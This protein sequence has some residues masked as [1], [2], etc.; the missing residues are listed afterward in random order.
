MIGMSYWGIAAAAILLAAIIVRISYDLVQH[1]EI[2]W[3]RYTQMFGTHGIN[4]GDLVRL[5]LFAL[6]LVQIAGIDILPIP[7]TPE[8]DLI[9]RTIGIGCAMIA[10]IFLTWPRIMRARTWGGGTVRPEDIEG[11]E[12]V[13][14][15]AYRYT[16]HPFYFGCLL[17]FTGVELALASYLAMIMPI[18]CYAGLNKIARLE[19]EHLADVY[20]EEYEKYVARSHRFLP[21]PRLRR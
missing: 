12:L 15:G 20:G 16:R 7:L 10:L 6:V 2:G 18:I 19:E 1:E 4:F 17:Y 8:H 13:T 14:Y 11:H 9:L 5:A 21:L 3:M